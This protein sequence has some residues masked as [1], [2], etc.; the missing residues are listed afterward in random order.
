M[1]AKTPS[2]EVERVGEDVQEGVTYVTFLCGAHGLGG[3]DFE[4]GTRTRLRFQ[5]LRRP[6]PTIVTTRTL[7]WGASAASPVRSLDK[8]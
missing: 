2:G 3:R 5:A 4:D 8:P 1:L 6:H 7:R